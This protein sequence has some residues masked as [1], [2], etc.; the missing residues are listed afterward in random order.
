[1][2]KIFKQNEIYIFFIMIALIIIITSFNRSFFT[3]E[4]FFDLLKGHSYEGI[5]A[6]GFFLVL[7]SGGIDVSFTAIAVVGMY[8]GVYTLILTGLNNIFIALLV[9]G[10]VGILLGAINALFIGVFKIPTLITTL[11]TLSAFQGGLMSYLQ[12]TKQTVISDPPTSIVNFGKFAIFRIVTAKGSV[13]EL[14]I[15]GFIFA[16]FAILTWVILKY[17][18]LGRSIK[19]MGGNREAAKRAGFNILRIQFFIYCY[20][21]FMAGI[22]GLMFGSYLRYIDP[23]NLVGNELTIIA[24]VVLGGASIMGGRGSII[25]TVIGVS[26][27]TILNTSLVFM[28]V[29]QYFQQAVIGAI[30]VISV[31][32]T[33]YRQKRKDR[34]TRVLDVA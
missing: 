9:A 19:A 33:A 21:G 18:T 14:S 11:G 3:L 25:G 5:L 13:I 26:I 31:S 12:A 10:L 4:N 17:T 6:I 27:I 2:R 28:K 34:E 29:P 15:F 7:L 23:L 22:A 24:A 32:I 30:I 1:M 16:F 8:I 20:V